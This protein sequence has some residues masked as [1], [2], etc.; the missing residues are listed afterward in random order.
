MD[1]YRHRYDAR[2]NR[3][4]PHMDLTEPALGF[5]EMARGMGVDGVQVTEP[6]QVAPAIRKG[7]ASGAPYLVDLV[8]SGKV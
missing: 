8:V 2:S 7:F 5:V 3:P 4:Y 1:I 6:E